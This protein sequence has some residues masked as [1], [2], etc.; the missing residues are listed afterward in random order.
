MMSK[1]S[2]FAK[3]EVAAGRPNPV[4]FLKNVRHCML[5][6]FCADYIREVMAD[7]CAERLQEAAGKAR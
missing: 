5:S 6:D 3:S 2:E 7:W 4:I 1:E